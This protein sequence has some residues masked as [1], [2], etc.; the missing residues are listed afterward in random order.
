MHVRQAQYTSKPLQWNVHPARIA[1]FE[2]RL[3]LDHFQLADVISGI[4]LLFT[5]RL[6][7]G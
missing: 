1:R 6:G 7:G 3:Q 2:R 4:S 5:W